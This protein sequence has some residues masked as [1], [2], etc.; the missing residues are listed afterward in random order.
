MFLNPQKIRGRRSRYMCPHSIFCYSNAI[1][2]FSKKFLLYEKNSEMSIGNVTGSLLF[3]FLF[4]YEKYDAGIFNN[5]EISLKIF[6]INL[7]L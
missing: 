7:L 3:S 4:S 6:L 2:S 1:F 5:S